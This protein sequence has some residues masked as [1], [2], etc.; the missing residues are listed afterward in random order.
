MQLKLTLILVLLAAVPLSADSIPTAQPAHKLRTH[1]H[2]VLAS[3][4]RA[5]SAAK[6]FLAKAPQDPAGQTAKA[7]QAVETALTAV[8]AELDVVHGQ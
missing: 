7:Q 3:A 1:P 2:S 8:S 6:M 4:Q 5:L